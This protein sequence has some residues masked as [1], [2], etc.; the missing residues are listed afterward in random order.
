M[1]VIGTKKAAFLLVACQPNNWKS[2]KPLT[3]R[4]QDSGAAV[5]FA[6]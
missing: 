6:E 4:M 5:T 3:E 2:A 1:S